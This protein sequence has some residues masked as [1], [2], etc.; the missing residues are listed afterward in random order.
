MIAP[1]ALHLNFGEQDSGSP[2]ESVKRG[3]Q[4]IAAVY[5]KA[6]VPENFTWFIEPDKGHVLSEAMWQHVKERFAGI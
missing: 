4:R 3:I 2:I 5:Q 6:G 1:R